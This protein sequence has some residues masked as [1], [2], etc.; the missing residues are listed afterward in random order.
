MPKTYC[1][2]GIAAYLS[3]LLTAEKEPLRVVPILVT[4]ATMVTLMPV[5][6]SA[7]S[8]AVAPDSFRRKSDTSF[9][10]KRTVNSH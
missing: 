10:L 4:A 7:Y 5:A 6:I 3:E 2:S 1:G 9:E 8:I